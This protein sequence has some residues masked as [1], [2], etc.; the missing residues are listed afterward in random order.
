MTYTTTNA[1]INSADYRLTQRPARPVCDVC[2]TNVATYRH[3]T[4]THN[5]NVCRACRETGSK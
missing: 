5:V 4:G 2:N 3:W 1:N